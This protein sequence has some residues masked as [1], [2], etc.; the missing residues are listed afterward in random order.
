MRQRQKIE[1]EREIRGEREKAA[2]VYRS[3]K[4]VK[5]VKRDNTEFP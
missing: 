2:S 4:E 3:K 5:K 1:T